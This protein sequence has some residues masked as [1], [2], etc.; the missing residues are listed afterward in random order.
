MSEPITSNPNWVVV[1][2]YGAA[3]FSADAISR[4]PTLGSDLR[5]DAELLHVQMGTLAEAVRAALR[6]GD[7]QLPSEVCEFLAWVLN[8]P[9]AVSEI[10]NAVAISFVEAEE[11]RASKVGLEVLA[12]MPATVRGVLVAQEARGGAP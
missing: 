7:S 3:Q 10:E 6:L 4:F 2:V 5:E 11:F 8:Q 9:H 1:D 12:R